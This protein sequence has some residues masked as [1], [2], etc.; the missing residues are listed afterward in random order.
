MPLLTNGSSC[1]S[2]RAC[3]YGLW[4]TYDPSQ[5]SSSCLCTAD[6]YWD[7]TQSYCGKTLI[8][9]MLFTIFVFIFVFIKV[10]KIGYSST[11]CTYASQCLNN[12]NLIC[13]ANTCTCNTA[14]Q[15]WNGTYCG[16]KYKLTKPSYVV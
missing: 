10:K 14:T 12:T 7:S 5:D 13:S 9:T 6:R 3:G 4:C 8:I 15:Y 11:G 2:T 1:T 16:K